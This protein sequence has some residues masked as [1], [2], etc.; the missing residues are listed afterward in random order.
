VHRAFACKADLLDA[1]AI[2][3]WER[4][5]STVRAHR[6]R[7]QRALA[8]VTLRHFER[9]VLDVAEGFVRA[10]AFMVVAEQVGGRKPAGV[11]P[12][13]ASVEQELGLLYAAAGGEVAAPRPGAIGDVLAIV[14]SYRA[15]E[16][17]H[18]RVALLVDGLAAR[19]TPR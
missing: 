2:D 16:R 15:P 18:E 3:A 4:T 17:V 19:E 1:V 7:A 9:A 14:T 8:P 12:L 5:L 11:L 6:V 13:V 10:D